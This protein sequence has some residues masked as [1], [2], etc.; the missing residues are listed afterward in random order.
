[1][2]FHTCFPFIQGMGECIEIAQYGTN[3]TAIPSQPI[4]IGFPK[5]F[6]QRWDPKSLSPCSSTHF[7]GPCLAWKDA[8]SPMPAQTYM[9]VEEAQH[10]W[11]QEKMKA[12]L[13]PLLC[14]YEKSRKVYFCFTGSV[15]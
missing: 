4:L 1:M 3:Q 8:C 7:S 13:A 11:K 5:C 2:G 15:L 12:I 6:T 9:C 10:D 14:V